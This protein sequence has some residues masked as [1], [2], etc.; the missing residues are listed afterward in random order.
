DG[1]GRY[2]FGQAPDLIAEANGNISLIHSAS[3]VSGFEITQKKTLIYAY[4]GGIY[5]VRNTAIDTTEKLVGYGIP[6]TTS[7]NQNRAIQEATFGFNQGI[8]KSPK[9][10]AVNL[11]GQYSY[12]VRDPWNVNV[13]ATS[14]SNAN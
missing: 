10:G 4:Y 12:L 13:T 1:G 2:I 3:T 7:G 14:P 8:W 5:I 11:M 9:Y 6:G